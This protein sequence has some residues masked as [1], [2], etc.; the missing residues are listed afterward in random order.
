M[1]WPASRL[2]SMAASDPMI[3]LPSV[4]E[5]AEIDEVEASPYAYKKLWI[6]KEHGQW[7]VD[8]P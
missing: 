6:K 4:P 5:L 8:L 1:R 7:R 2:I 3:A